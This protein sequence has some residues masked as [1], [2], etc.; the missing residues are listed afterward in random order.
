MQLIV[1]W[2]KYKYA[3]VADSNEI[4]TYLVIPAIHSHVVL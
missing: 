2:M 1:S 4:L 3:P